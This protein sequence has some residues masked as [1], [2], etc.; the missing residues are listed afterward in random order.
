MI[1]ELTW[2]FRPAE[3]AKRASCSDPGGEALCVPIRR[4]GHLRAYPPNV[5]FRSERYPVELI[6]LK[7]IYLFTVSRR[8]KC[9]NI[10]EPSVFRKRPKH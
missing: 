5:R 7:F 3:W 2:R 8:K 9:S 10:L 4:L 6:H 1:C